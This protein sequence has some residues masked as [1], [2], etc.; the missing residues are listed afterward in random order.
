MKNKSSRIVIGSFV[1][2]IIL[3]AFIFFFLMNQMAQRSRD[4]TAEIS[5]LYLE[6]MS[7][8]I[9]SHFQTTIDIKLAQ[10]E[11]IIKTMPPEG[12]LQ[13]AEL[14]E[15]MRISAVA[16]EFKFLALLAEDGSFEQILGAPVSIPDTEPFLDDLIRGDKKIA[17]A[18]VLG[19]ELDLVLLGVPCQYDMKDGNKSVALVGGID[20]EY[21]YT[22]LSLDNGDV[23]SYSHIIRRNGD[24][25]IKSSV[26]E[27]DNFYDRIY[28]V[29]KDTDGKDAESYEENIKEAILDRMLYADIVTT[30][31]G[32]KCVYVTP[33]A[34]S[35]WYLVTVMS[36]EDLDHIM[37]K[38]DNQRVSAFLIA[39]LGMLIIFIIVFVLYYRM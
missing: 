15:S 21:I 27:E 16:R 8:Q 11:S 38:L 30:H 25:V 12:E 26:A 13:G 36:F 6:R 18:D 17:V 23:D 7:A 20:L 24:F 29:V 19:Q 1:L 3:C 35:E 4:T 32:T 10:V 22:T 37:Q 14:A 9:S 33:L 2:M 31:S 5:D 28:T 39:L 34:Y